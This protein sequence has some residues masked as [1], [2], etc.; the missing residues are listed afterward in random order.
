LKYGKIIG[1]GNTATVYE[2]EEGTVLKLFDQGYPNKAVEREFQNAKAINGLNFAKPK[3]YEIIC[4]EGRMGILYD[5]VEGE[6]LLDWV[7]K[8]GDL[9]G[10]A[11]H[12][13]RLHKTI[14]QNK[15]SNVMNYKEF[16][17]SNILI[18]EA[19]TV[20][21]QKMY[22]YPGIK[23]SEMPSKLRDEFKDVAAGY[24]TFNLGD[25]GKEIQKRWQ[26]EVAGQ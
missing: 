10:C 21:T 20:I 13:A 6:S 11:E 15:V 17:K 26:Q 14:V 7:L 12:M 3:A 19:Q 8:T 23:W 4:C 25:L 24:R 2:W 16:L 22:G 18:P 9:Q 1:E 5:R